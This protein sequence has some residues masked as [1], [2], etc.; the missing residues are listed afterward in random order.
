MVYKK[1]LQRKE[2]YAVESFFFF[3]LHNGTRVFY[4]VREKV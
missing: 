3:W 4:E 1:E 2:K